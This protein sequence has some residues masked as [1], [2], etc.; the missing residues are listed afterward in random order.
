MKKQ[1][2]KAFLLIVIATLF[3]F[4]GM[5]SGQNMPYSVKPENPNIG[6]F[7][8]TM[9]PGESREGAVILLNHLEIPQ[10]FRVDIVDAHTADGGGL[11]YSYDKPRKHSYWV[12]TEIKDSIRLRG[13]RIQRIPFKVTV[14]ENTP[15]GEYYLGIL[16]S[17]DESQVTPE[18][19]IATEQQSFNIKVV[20]Q[21]A[22]AIVITVPDPN[23]CDVLIS[24]ITQSILSGRWNLKAHMINKGN[25]HFSGSGKLQVEDLSTN[26]PLVSRDIKIGYF[27]PGTE[28][29]ADYAFDMPPNGNYKVSIQIL[30][31]DHPGCILE[32]STDI[33]V[34]EEIAEVYQVQTTKI[35]EAVKNSTQVSV[36][37]DSPTQV[38]ATPIESSKESKLI[39]WISG[40]FLILAIGF[41][42]IAV[43]LLKK[44][45]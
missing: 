3:I 38:P 44:R 32:K 33:L 13:Q 9:N 22:I 34:G 35:A 18:P 8:F 30:D 2:Q 7:E 31:K 39:L 40:V 5:V 42:L 10:S 37:V 20:S 24:D 36:H 25:V 1:I 16:T 27:V 23:N 4:P 17:I 6:Y 14:P 26:T 12:E 41:V 43:L 11:A 15:P 28:M 19:T 29:N 45:K 21:I